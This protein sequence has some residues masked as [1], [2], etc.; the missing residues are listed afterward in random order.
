[1][2]AVLEIPQHRNTYWNAYNLLLREQNIN[3][4]PYKT[5]FDKFDKFI[6]CF[7]RDDWKL[8]FSANHRAEICRIHKSGAFG[9]A[10]EIRFNAFF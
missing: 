8:F 7:K 10:E 6:L 9:L 4:S 1:M 3:V 2:S 5:Y